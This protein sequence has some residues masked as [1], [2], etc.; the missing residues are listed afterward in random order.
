MDRWQMV[1]STR[2]ALRRAVIPRWHR[3]LGCRLHLCRTHAA[4][5]LYG[6]RERHRPA[7]QDLLGFRD[8]NRRRMACKPSKKLR[9]RSLIKSQNHSKLPGYLKFEPRP[10]PQ[11]GF[12]FRAASSEAVDWLTKTL[13]FNPLKRITARQVGCSSDKLAT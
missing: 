11:L 2:A 1:P 12:L 7:R 8:A 5:P 6:W 13:A 3:C 10:K 4:S 9:G